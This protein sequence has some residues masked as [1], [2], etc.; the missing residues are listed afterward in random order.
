[1]CRWNAYFGQP[2]LI[3]ELLFK[4]DHGLID[5]SLHARMGVE[6]TN[7]DGFGLG[8]YAAGGERPARY[9]SITPAW[10]DVNLRE[11]TAHV[12][13]PLFLAHIRATTGTPVQ[14]TNCH[15]F[16]HREWLFVHNGVI[17]GFHLIR[18][19]LMVAIDPE[20]FDDVAGSTD[21]EVMFYLALTFGLTDD[22]L[23]GLERAVG[24][25]EA[26]ARAHEIEHPVQMTVGLSDGHHLWAVRYSSEG[27]SRTL[28]ISE[29]VSALKALHPESE[30]LQAL[31]PEDRAVVS[32]PLGDRLPGAWVAVPEATAWV[33]QPGPDERRPFQPR[34]PEAASV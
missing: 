34:V 10:S 25:I 29:D 8:W 13:S 28:Y 5:Q 15:P 19:E 2:L 31:G 30:Q 14:Q 3:D 23:A 12:K 4:M 21:S 32:E 18:R 6:T 1:M 33:I 24:F 20:L 11:L 22:P 26:T 27:K 7:G 9:R 17:N 16:R